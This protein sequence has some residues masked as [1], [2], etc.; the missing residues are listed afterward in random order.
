[1]GL[2]R[3]NCYVWGQSTKDGT[4]ILFISILYINIVFFSLVFGS[5]ANDQVNAECVFQKDIVVFVKLY[6]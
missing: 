1:M 2:Q 4:H 3:R 5:C 6:Q